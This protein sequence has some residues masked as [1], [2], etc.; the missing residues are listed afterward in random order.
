MAKALILVLVQ[1]ERIANHTQL[2]N[3]GAV[4]PHCPNCTSTLI[5]DWRGIVTAL[6]FCIFADPNAVYFI[7]ARHFSSKRLLI[8]SLTSMNSQY[9]FT[10]DVTGGQPLMRFRRVAQVV[11]SRNRQM[12]ASHDPTPDVC[13]AINTSLA[14][15]G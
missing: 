8:T 6:V 5:L 13:N 15:T 12:L 1:F 9:N 3:R 4:I 2:Q 11:F 7:P 14:S 10:K